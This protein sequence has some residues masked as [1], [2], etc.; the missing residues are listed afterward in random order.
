YPQFH[1]ARATIM[2]KTILDRLAS[3]AE[4]IVHLAAAVGVQLIV[5]RP[6]NTIETNIGGTEAVLKAA[7]RYNAR[8]LIA[9]TSEVY[10][11]GLKVPF[12]ERDDV[13][14]G[15]TDKSRWAYAASKMVDEFLGHA[16]YRE[17]G[18]PVVLFRLFNTIGPRQSGQYGMVAPRFVRSALRNQP[19]QVF[20][21]GKQSRCFCHVSDVVRALT[22]LS[23]LPQAV[24]QLFNI[25]SG[26]EISILHLAERVI[27]LTGSRSE[28]QFVPYEQA[29]SEGFEDMSRR[30]PSTEKLNSL[31]RWKPSYSLDDT[32]R[33]IIDYEKGELAVQAGQGMINGVEHAAGMVE[34]LD[35]KRSPSKE[36]SSHHEQA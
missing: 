11:K 25:G 30:M 34:G 16:Y 24:G 15:T 28:I 23:E 4:V 32:L 1:F 17:F 20:G 33:S 7:L 26:E 2:D 8:V 6:V 22:A 19:L 9:S 36:R 29:Y 21:D 13:V 18:L 3:S 12:D 14:L 10:G 27:A 5:E 31:A 35:K